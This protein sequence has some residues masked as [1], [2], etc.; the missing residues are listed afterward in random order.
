MKEMYAID[1]KLTTCP[2][3]MEMGM[4]QQSMDDRK[5]ILY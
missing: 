4:C 3:E 1:I 2:V 5:E